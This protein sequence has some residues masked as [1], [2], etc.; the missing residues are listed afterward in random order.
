MQR[1]FDVE[2]VRAQFAAL[3]R[4]HEGRPVASFDGPGGSQ[5][6]RSSMDGIAG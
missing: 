6:A 4:L 3:A 5:A 2:A 1:T